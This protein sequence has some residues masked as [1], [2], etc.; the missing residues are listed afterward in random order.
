MKRYDDFAVVI[1]PFFSETTAADATIEFISS[2]CV[3]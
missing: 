3:I 1:Q 2:V